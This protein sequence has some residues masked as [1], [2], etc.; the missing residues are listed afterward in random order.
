MTSGLRKVDASQMTHKNPE[1]RTTSVV[2]DKKAPPIKAKP[3][4]LSQ[5]PKKP[6]RTELE[7]GNKWIIVSDQVGSALIVGKSRGQSRH[8]HRPD[9]AQSHSPRIRVQ[10]HHN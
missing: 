9:R 6:A 4:S 7:D 10:E 8:Q 1:L 5:A 2:P 3:G